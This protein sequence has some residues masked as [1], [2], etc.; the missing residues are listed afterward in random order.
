MVTAVWADS[1]NSKRHH[2]K[3]VEPTPTAQPSQTAQPSPTAEPS[4]PAVSNSGFEI[5]VDGGMVSPVSSGLY[6]T[7]NS[8]YSFGGSLGYKMD[9][10]SLLLDTQYNTLNLNDPNASGTFNIWEGALVEKARL[11]SATSI[12]PF[13]FVGEGLAVLN[14]SGSSTSESYSM[15]EAG[16][17]MDFNAGEGIN[18]FLQTKGAFVLSSNLTVAPDSLTI[19]LPF[20]LGMD[21]VL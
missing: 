8:S 18:V 16:V 10:F 1:A 12:K 17:G 7:Y 9:W 5:R 2:V 11:E 20:Q 6:Q 13:I 3:K 19:Y 15:L 4:P 14:S 21:F